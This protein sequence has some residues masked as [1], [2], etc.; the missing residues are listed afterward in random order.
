MINLLIKTHDFIKNDK[1]ANN[2]WKGVISE[3]KK[4]EKRA[5]LTRT[6]PPGLVLAGPD[7][8][9]SRL[10]VQFGTFRVQNKVF[11]EISR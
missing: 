10:L 1:F 9:K 2:K 3:R 8:S 5:L 7:M 11:D 4:E 6:C